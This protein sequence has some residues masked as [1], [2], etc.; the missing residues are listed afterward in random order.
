MID[1]TTRVN[2]DKCNNKRCNKNG[3]VWEKDFGM[4]EQKNGAFGA[5]ERI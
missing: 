5:G 2:Y 4:R 1:I 3:F